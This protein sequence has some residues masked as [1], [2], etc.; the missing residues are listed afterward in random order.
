MR[1]VLVEVS[2]GLL[3]LVGTCLFLAAAWIGVKFLAGLLP[4]HDAFASNEELAI[5][6]DAEASHRGITLVEPTVIRDVKA[7]D[8]ESRTL[9]GV[10]ARDG[11][12]NVWVLLDPKPASGPIVLPDKE[13]ELTPAQFASL[14][15][16]VGS[17]AVKRFLKER[18]VR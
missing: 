12:G 13:F 6:Q 15:K 7:R 9:L 5:V 10:P 8:G 18:V 2:G 1:R 4:G 14:E 16:A 17:E 11:S 3:I